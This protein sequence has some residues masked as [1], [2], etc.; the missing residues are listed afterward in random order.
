MIASKYSLKR[1]RYD[2]GGREESVFAFYF[3]TGSSRVMRC[4]SYR[5]FHRIA[6]R[7][8]I[9]LTEFPLMTCSRPRRSYTRSNKASYDMQSLLTIVPRFFFCPPSRPSSLASSRTRFK[10]ISKPRRT[11]ETFREPC[12]LM[13]RRLSMYCV[14]HIQ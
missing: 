2:F 7:V 3:S 9:E 11:P 5:D 8:S 1:L 10:K 14:G 6:S 12:R 13:N 4:P